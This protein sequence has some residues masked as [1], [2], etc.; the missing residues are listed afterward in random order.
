MHPKSELVF[1][2]PGHKKKLLQYINSK[3]SKIKTNKLKKTHFNSMLRVFIE[4]YLHHSYKNNSDIL[5]V[6]KKLPTKNPDEFFEIIESYLL[7]NP[8]PYNYP[9]YYI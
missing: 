8:N 5:F 9:K 7:K 6:K 1:R 4:H 3:S 2:F